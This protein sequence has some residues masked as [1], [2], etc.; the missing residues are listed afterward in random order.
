[1]MEEIADGYGR[2]SLKMI[3]DLK[4]T[5]RVQFEADQECGWSR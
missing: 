2:L 4:S 1:M 3:K 5:G